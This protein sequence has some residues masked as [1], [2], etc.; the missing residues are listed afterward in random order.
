MI[1]DGKGRLTLTQ[2]AQLAEVM[3]AVAVVISLVF[4]GREL[5]S[6]TAAIRAASVQA[7][8][9]ASS[10]A[11]RDLALDSALARIRQIG[12]D[13]LSAL[14]SAEQYRF[15][16]WSR[17]RWLSMQNY[18]FQNEL[19]V[20]EPGVWAGYHNAICSIARGPGER[21]EWPR[22]RSALDSGFVALVEACEPTG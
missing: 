7:A 17:Q 9:I 6:N 1:E 22:H 14:S 10:D 11:L 15:T 18:Y 3:A 2:L 21:A 4:V 12:E 16:L 5:R 13:N 19:G 20:F 8:A